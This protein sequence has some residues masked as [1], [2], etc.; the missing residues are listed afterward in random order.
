MPESPVR[1]LRL[2]LTVEDYEGAIAFYRDVLGLPVTESWD[3]P[4]GSGAVM[5]AGR[6]TLELLSTAQA[7]LVDRVEV[8]S[9]DVRVRAPDGMQLTLFTVLEADDPPDP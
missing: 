7:E 5:D 6:A 2:A 4:D 8:G 1:E 3:G 9:R